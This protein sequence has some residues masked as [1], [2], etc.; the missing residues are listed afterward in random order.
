MTNYRKTNAINLFV[1]VTLILLG[2]GGTVVIAS[3]NLASSNL[4]WTMVFLSVFILV[5]GYEIG[6]Y[7][8]MRYERNRQ[9]SNLN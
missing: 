4:F 5:G 2:I 8:E 9:T 1:G 3:T 7:V 6:K